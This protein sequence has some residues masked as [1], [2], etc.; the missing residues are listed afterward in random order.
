MPRKRKINLPL[1]EVFLISLAVHAL[2]LFALGGLTIYRSMMHSAVDFESA[3]P[4]ERVQ[5]QQ[6]QVQV[7]MQQQQRQSS[8][9]RQTMTV[10]NVS[11]MNV[12]QVEVQ[13]PAM[14]SRI[15]TPMGGTRG[16]VASNLGSGR[17]GMEKSSVNFFGIQ[18]EGERVTFIID[19]SRYMMED[20][21]GG[22]HAYRIVKEEIIEMV[23]KLEPATLFNVLL[24]EYGNRVTAFRPAMVPANTPNKKAFAEWLRPLN[25]D[26]DNLGARIGESYSIQQPMEPILGGLSRHWRAFHAAMELQTDAIFF[27]TGGWSNRLQQPLPENF[28]LAEWRRRQGWNEEKA[29]AYSAA[30]QRARDWLERENKAREARGMPPMVVQH[31]HSVLRNQ[32]NDDTPAAPNP[33]RNFWEQDDLMRYFR[34]LGQFLYPGERNPSPEINVIIFRG[35][36]EGW[37]DS[38]DQQVRDFVRRNRGTHRVLEG[39]EGV[40]AVTG[41]S[42]G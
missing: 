1:I 20:R 40:Q 4:P 39:L 24:Y 6:Q 5:P 17:I 38:D 19:A 11:D 36:D 28:D 3:P 41:R 22:M 31:I 30:I 10:Q 26:P 42:G 27:I 29:A 12:P 34:R 15:A 8:R 25:E 37:T 23:N 32:L 9:P 18:S 35:K 13:V 14:S 33:P 21:K 16:T 2:I 7:R